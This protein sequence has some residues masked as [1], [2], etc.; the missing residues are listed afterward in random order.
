MRTKEEGGR[1][2]VRS[3]LGK[4]IEGYS[5]R[6]GE[7]FARDVEITEFSEGEGENISSS[8]IC[9][10]RSSGMR[11]EDLH[12]NLRSSERQSAIVDGLSLKKKRGGSFFH[13]HQGKDSIKSLQKTACL[14]SR[15]EWKRHSIFID[16]SE[17]GLGRQ[18]NATRNGGKGA[19]KLLK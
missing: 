1:E 18:S 9:S 10:E 3:A 19:F 6:R 17:E 15:E 4:D 8:I 7:T 11:G 13:L 5:R 16:T 12:D 2:S 14:S